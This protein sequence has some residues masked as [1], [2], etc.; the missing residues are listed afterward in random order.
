MAQLHSYLIHH[1]IWCL[2]LSWPVS[3]VDCQLS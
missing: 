3:R 1:C 2:F